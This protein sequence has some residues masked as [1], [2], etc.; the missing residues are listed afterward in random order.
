[1]IP[2]PRR[3]YLRA[4]FCELVVRNRNL[5]AVLLAKALYRAAARTYRNTCC[6]TLP[7][8]QIK[9]CTWIN[10]LSVWPLL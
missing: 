5:T 2:C 3:P 9:W 8:K 7:Y 6:F 10:Y 1:M 4:S